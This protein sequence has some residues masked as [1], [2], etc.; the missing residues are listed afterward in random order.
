MIKGLELEDGE[1]S[2]S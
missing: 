1:R 2:I